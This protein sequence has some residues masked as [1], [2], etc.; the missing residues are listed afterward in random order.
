VQPAARSANPEEAS[1]GG[2]NVVSDEARSESRE[3]REPGGI[4]DP[5]GSRPAAGD[6]ATGT[7]SDERQRVF[8]WPSLPRAF[9]T[10][11]NPSN[12]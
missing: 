1:T 11:A 9:Y 12:P 2:A 10:K 8:R 3:F 5:A 6:E 7:S 4:A